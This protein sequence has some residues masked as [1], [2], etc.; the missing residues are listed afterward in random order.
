MMAIVRIFMLLATHVCL[1][2][3]TPTLHHR[4]AEFKTILKESR[5]LFFNLFH[6][7]KVIMIASSVEHCYAR[8]KENAQQ[9]VRLGSVR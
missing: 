2:T 1:A 5:A 3:A 9:T 8:Y 4:T 6:T 7:D